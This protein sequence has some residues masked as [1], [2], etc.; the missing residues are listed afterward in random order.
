[1]S[2]LG[3]PS[4]WKILKIP[5]PLRRRS[6]L[7]KVRLLLN[8]MNSIQLHKYNMKNAINTMCCIQ[9]NK[10][11]MIPTP[12]VIPSEGEDNDIFCSKDNIY[13]RVMI[14]REHNGSQW[15]SVGK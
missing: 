13:G 11:S 7:T 9:C 4:Y 5:D 6:N 2:S 12:K 14:R 10:Y 8:L 3:T 1:M 15:V